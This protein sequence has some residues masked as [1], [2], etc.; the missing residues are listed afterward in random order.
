M[1]LRRR[2]WCLYLL[3]FTWTRWTTKAVGKWIAR[4]SS[5]N[6]PRADIDLLVLVRILFCRGNLCQYFKSILSLVPLRNCTVIQASNKKTW[7][8]RHCP[9]TRG[10]VSIQLV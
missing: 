9:L 10:Y 2:A 3:L 7:I 5:P 4:P 6:D 1:G 8:T